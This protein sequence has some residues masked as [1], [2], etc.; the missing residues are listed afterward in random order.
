[1]CWDD[2]AP[3]R[4]P[5]TGTATRTAAGKSRTLTRGRRIG[6]PAVGAAG[7]AGGWVFSARAGV[8]AIAA[9]AELTRERVRQLQ[10]KAED[11]LHRA[12][13]RHDP[14]LP[15]RLVTELGDRMAVPE[16][17]IAQL[18]P[19]S[20]SAARFALLRR[21]GVAPPRMCPGDLQGYWTRKPAQLDT[22]LS[23]LAAL[24]P[25]SSSEAEAAA[26]ELGIP[27]DL[28]IE[29]LLLRP[30]SK[31]S[32]H[33]LGWIRNGRTGRDLA[34]LWLREQGEPRPV[35]DI[36]TVTGTSEHA[37]RETMR[38]DDDFAQLRPE[39]TWALA[40]WHLPGSDNR[41]S[42]AVEVVVDVLRE[43]GP[44]DYDRLRGEARTATRS[45][46]G[47]SRSACLTTVSG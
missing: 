40:D 32:H 16:A 1:M 27:T 21:L 41:Y 19:T 33:E 34:Y 39:G 7:S 3:E 12:Q 13:R 45:A 29:R 23:Q 31:L 24:A 46:P 37:I 36:A 25:M 22:R 8:Q 4:S 20:A 42:N 17:E 11:D 14:D 9:D 10:L 15:Q 28:P 38:R 26:V 35:S 47:E 5:R 30:K 44:L 6:Y 2:V 43:L 18:V